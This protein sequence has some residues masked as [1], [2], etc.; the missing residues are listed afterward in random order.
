ME[1]KVLEPE[2]LFNF[3]TPQEYWILHYWNQLRQETDLHL[4]LVGKEVVF[5]YVYS[6]GYSVSLLED[7]MKKMEK[8]AM[9]NLKT[10]IWGAN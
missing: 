1:I 4:E 3:A 5:T 10:E 9:L 2:N 6:L 8:L 7:R